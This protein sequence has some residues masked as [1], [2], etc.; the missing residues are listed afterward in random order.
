MERL[1]ADGLNLRAVI[2]LTFTKRYYNPEVHC[3]GVETKDILYCII[4]GSSCVQEFEKFGVKYA[5][6]MCP[7]KEIPNDIVYSQ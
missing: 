3:T 2:D 7:G 6:I 5:K 1:K 4:E